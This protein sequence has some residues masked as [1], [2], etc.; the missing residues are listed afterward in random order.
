MPTVESLTA[1]ASSVASQDNP[2]RQLTWSRQVLNLVDRTITLE[3]ALN[4]SIDQAHALTEP[5]LHALVDQAIPQIMRQCEAVPPSAAPGSLPPHIAEAFYLRGTLASSSLFQEWVKKDL[6]QSFKDFE[7]AARSGCHIGWFRIGRDYEGVQ[8]IRRARDA[9]E[10]GVR[11]GEKNCLYRMGMAQLQGHLELPMNPELA[12]PLLKQAADDADTESPQAAYI[13]GMILLG[14]FA[15]IEIPS[16]ALLRYLPRPSSSNPDPRQTEAR[17]YIER[18]A[19]LC[20]APAQTKIAWAYEFARM[21][22]PFDPL[23]SVQFYSLASQQG[24]EEA[25]MALS[26]WFLCGAEGHFEK[27]EYL[28]YTFAEKAARKGLANAEFAMGYYNEVGVGTKADI[29]MAKRWYEKAAQHNNA[30]ALARLRALSSLHPESLSRT[31]HESI[32][33]NKLVRKRTQAKDSSAAA[34]RRPVVA[35][36]GTSDGGRFAAEVAQNGLAASSRLMAPVRSN[37]PSPAP[38]PSSSPPQVQAQPQPM[39]SQAPRPSQSQT[40]PSSGRPSPASA[41]APLPVPDAGRGRGRFHFGRKS[42][43]RNQLPQSSTPPSGNAGKPISLDGP[44][45]A[46]T[47]SS[48]PAAP[49]TFAEMGYHSQALDDKEC[50]IM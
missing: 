22:C 21:G 29:G 3:T 27:E 39:P 20:Y 24:E 44:S 15:H 45:G 6:R 48:N 34:G 19:Y 26:K 2:P 42:A 37:G 36:T 14:E 46:K 18:A 35:P 23:L 40:P 12:I 11:L 43:E 33:H 4:P 1:A 31:Q 16:L 49:R 28:A 50:I 38:Y 25:D 8:D 9:F 13:L 17:R 47:A 10:R 32:T 5:R 7:T 30:D 41:A